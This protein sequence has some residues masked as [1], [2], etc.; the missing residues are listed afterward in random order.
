VE[1]A[2]VSFALAFA[3]GLAS[4]LSPCVLPIVPGYVT[5]VTGVTLDDLQGARAAGARKRAALHAGFFILG[6]SV[7]FIILGASATALGGVVRRLL[8]VIQQIGGVFIIVFGLYMLGVI[9]IPALMRERRF[10]LGA[11]PGGILGSAAAGV[12]FGAGWTPCIGPVLASILL[13]AGM[14]TSLLHG[15]ALLAAYALGL[16]IPFFIAAVALN[17]YLA[18]TLGLRRWLPHIERGAGVVLVLLGALLFTGHFT[19]L[20][21]FFAGL[22]QLVEL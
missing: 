6:F 14:N 1:P 10:Q 21:Q 19:A 2:S 11:K 15:I 7:L 5:F 13:Y 4:F 17:W 9:K 12:V 8:P 16:G 18:R 3:A 22:G 20:A